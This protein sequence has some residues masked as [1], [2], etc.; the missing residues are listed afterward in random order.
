MALNQLLDNKREVAMSESSDC[1][2]F[3]CAFGYKKFEDRAFLK[4]SM[5]MIVVVSD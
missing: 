1:S 5:V 4:N 2:S 3:C